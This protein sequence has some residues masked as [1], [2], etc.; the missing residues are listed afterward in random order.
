MLPSEL[1]TLEGLW[2]LLAGVF[3]V[4]YALTDGFDLGTG[5][6]HLF[7]KDEK[8]RMT[9]MDSIAPVWDG[10]EVWLIAGGGMLFAAF[11]VVYAASFSGFY[12][13]IMIVLWA[14]IGRAV[15]FE[16]RNKKESTSWRKTWDVIYWI[17]NFVPAL[18]FG[19][20]VGNAVL[21]VPIDVQGRYQ[22]TFFDLLN[23]PSLMIGV[24]GLFMFMMH[25]AAWLLLKTEGSV[26]EKAKKWAFVSW[27]GFV[28]MLIITDF[29][30]LLVKPELYDNYFKY[31]L[32]LIAPLLMIVGLIYY[33]NQLMIKK[34]YEKV[35]WGSA[36][37][38]AGTVLTIACASFPVFI[39]STI[40]PKYNLDIF[41][42]ASSHLTLTVILVV[43]VLFLPIVL[44]Y[45]AYVY[46]VFK[47]KVK[48][49]E[50][51]H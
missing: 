30:L 40:D 38:V 13:A 21:G 12:L 50:G 5:I 41:N 20:A 17:G 51:Y 31:P 1:F 47:G 23:I 10:N 6:V 36:L 32:L 4:G 49:G 25:G 18:L 43:T 15:A 27:I 19:V 26:F 28:I 24:V 2:F 45:T 8:E 16:Y 9:M 34:N 22:G 7:T 39:R 3:L 35:I 33:F 46:K 11:P 48:E 44:F 14:L 29:V 37:T 42:S